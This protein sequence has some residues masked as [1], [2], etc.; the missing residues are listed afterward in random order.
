[1]EEGT[2]ERRK[3]FEAADSGRL[4]LRRAELH[5]RR[6]RP[7]DCTTVLHTH[8]KT[9][10]CTE[11]AEDSA[12]GAACTAFM[13]EH[14]DLQESRKITSDDQSLTRATKNTGNISMCTRW[15]ATYRSKTWRTCDAPFKYNC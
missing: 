9:L 11:S 15:E 8:A 5:V 2:E 14:K 3:T 7:L 13:H 12:Q 6:A 10:N 1:M 4:Q